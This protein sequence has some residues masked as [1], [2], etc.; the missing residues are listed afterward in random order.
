MT[1]LANYKGWTAEER[2]A[3]LAKTKQAIKDGIIPPPHAC[4]LCEQD[5]GIIQYHNEDYSHPTKYLRSWCWRCHMIHHS[6]HF[7]PVQCK[8]YF[9]E[10][11]S[12]K[13]YPPVFKHDFGILVREH[14]IIKSCKTE[15]ADIKIS[16]KQNL[17]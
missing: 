2:L 7:A 4:E 13:I 10:I 1:K 3:S 14:G 17:G 16:S 11:A 5:K 6:Q 9:D 12:G 15:K 8:A